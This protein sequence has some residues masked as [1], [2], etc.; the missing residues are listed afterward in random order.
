MCSFYR[1]S[2]LAAVMVVSAAPDV[3]SAVVHTSK[4]Y[5]TLYPGSSSEENEGWLRQG[6]VAVFRCAVASHGPMNITWSHNGTQLVADNV[7]VTATT[8]HR[9]ALYNGREAVVTEGVLTVASLR[10]SDSGRYTCM[11]RDVHGDLSESTVLRVLPFPKNAGTGCS[12][13]EDCPGEN[14]KCSHETRLCECQPHLKRSTDGGRVVCSSGIGVRGWFLW[15]GTAAAV[16]LIILSLKTILS[17]FVKRSPKHTL[18]PVTEESQDI[19]TDEG[20]T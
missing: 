17:C 1:A 11:F 20:E 15:L 18:L 3:M 14:I 19:K 12:T 4:D 6:E 8:T 10:L 16:L 7:S 2:I 5:D 9:S 13:D